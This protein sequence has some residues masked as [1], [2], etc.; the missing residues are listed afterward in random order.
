[1]FRWLLR[2]LDRYVLREWS[3]IFFG[4]ALG[5]PLIITIF[6]LT[7][8]LDKYL[9]RSL[10]R[11]DIALSYV[12]WFPESML[13]VMP[14]AVL[15]ATVFS[16]G[17][18]T[19][20][21]EITAAKASGLSFHRLV[22]PIVIGSALASGGALLLSEYVPAANKR[23]SEIL[24][25]SR[26]TTGN[27]RY[28]FAFAAERG[29]VYRATLLNVERGYL[30]GVE[31]ERKGREGDPT[32]PTWIVSARNAR[33]GKDT[34]WTIREGSLHVVPDR[35]RNVAFVFD[36]LRDRT[37]GESPRDLMA[38]PKAPADMGYDDLGRFI[39]A[40]E[41]SGSDVNKLRVD[42][43]LKI[44]VPIAC[45][46]IA[47]FGMPLATSNQRGGAAYG[48]GISLGTTI[49][50]LIMIQLTRAVGGQGG[51]SPEMAAWVPNIV[52]GVLGLLMFV[53]VRT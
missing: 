9:Q 48:I 13:L 25:E 37:M 11:Q 34:G 19:R 33:F 47:F 43:A 24:Q 39:A 45:F 21:S 31:V 38:S 49:V 4:T 42:R 23:R 14:A 10:S 7:D 26:Y 18:L 17:A 30:E 22:F 27:E 53:R 20:H 6:D 8:N 35:G 29:R 28:N 12:Y 50:F 40:L 46:I 5:F 36:S 51:L 3:K 2:P 15:F 52:F 1:M 44:A 41:R 32:Y 16:I